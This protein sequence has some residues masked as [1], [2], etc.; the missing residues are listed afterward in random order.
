ML[1]C[2]TCAA[3]G[4]YS[5]VRTLLPPSIHAPTRAPTSSAPNSNSNEVEVRCAIPLSGK[6]CGSYVHMDSKSKYGV[7]GGKTTLAQCAA[8]V[9]RLGSREG[10]KGGH[11]F[12]ES[13][14]YCNCPKDGCTTGP[15]GKAGSAGTL[16]RTSASCSS[17]TSG[18]LS[19]TSCDGSSPRARLPLGI[20]SA[21]S[22]QPKPRQILKRLLGSIL[23]ASVDI[24]TVSFFLL[25]FYMVSRSLYISSSGCSSSDKKISCGQ[26]IS[27]ANCISFYL[28]VCC[29]T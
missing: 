19:E 1:A 8:A 2:T 20:R 24:R 11:F 14:G 6:G 5:I 10:C 3:A 23:D 28:L 17:G 21:I 22:I 7:E 26:R 18:A 16:Y 29:A 12:F 13:A 15:N 9:Q 4:Q 25:W 27:R